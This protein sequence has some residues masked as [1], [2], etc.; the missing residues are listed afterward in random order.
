[1]KTTKL[2]PLGPS[3]QFEIHSHHFTSGPRS[4]AGYRNGKWEDTKF[5]HSHPGGSRPHR[6]PNCGPSNYGYR[7]PKVT[8]RP[9]GEQFLL[10]PMSEEESSFELIITDSAKP[11]PTLNPKT[12]KYE[13]PDIHSLSVEEMRMPAAETVKLGSRLTCIVRD[14]RKKRA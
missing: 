2:V 5:S 4:S 1:M 10:V 13:S 14:E 7:K 3:D 8:K 12:G 9:N 6:H 11:M